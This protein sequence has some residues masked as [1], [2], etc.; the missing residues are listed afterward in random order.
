MTSSLTNYKILNVDSVA[1]STHL[2][3]SSLKALCAVDVDASPEVVSALSRALNIA[4][5]SREIYA[6]LTS[7]VFRISVFSVKA[8]KYGLYQRYMTCVEQ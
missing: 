4:P 5:R 6:S 1:R 8:S 7:V 2:I 3:N